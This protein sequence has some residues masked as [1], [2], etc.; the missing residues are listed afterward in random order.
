MV[1]FWVWDSSQ[2]VNLRGS[3]ESVPP[4]RSDAKAFSDGEVTAVAGS[5]TPQRGVGVVLL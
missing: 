5:H 2:H 1:L 4:P 3:S